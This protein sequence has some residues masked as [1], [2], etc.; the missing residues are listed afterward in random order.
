MTESIRLRHLVQLRTD[1]SS[2]EL[3]VVNL[4]G[5]GQGTGSLIETPEIAAAD[6]HLRFHPGDVLFS[7]LRPYLAK[8]WLVDCDS[9][10][11]SELLAFTPG[12]DVD[13]RFLLYVTLSSPWL[14]WAEVTSYGTKMP[15]TSWEN[16]ADYR[17]WTP[18]LEV[19]RRIA[20]FLDDQ[21]DRIDH[22]IQ[23]IGRAH[24]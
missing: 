19:Q 21:V 14:E 20:D 12:S 13:A 15:R 24:V 9:H 5:I 4:D 18:P 6:G 11:T 8:S 22:A 7:K 2:E 23:Q 1:K 17:I 3:P 16:L 10:G